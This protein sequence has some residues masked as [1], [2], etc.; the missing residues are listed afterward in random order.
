[1]SPD[2]MLSGGGPYLVACPDEPDRERGETHEPEQPSAPGGDGQA[3]RDEGVLRRPG[4]LRA[5]HR[6]GG[7]PELPVR[8]RLG[9][10]AVLHEPR[11]E[12]DRRAFSLRREGPH[13]LHPDTGR[14]REGGRDDVS[15]RRA[16][17]PARRPSLG[18][19][20]LHHARP[21][22]DRPGF[23]SRPRRQSRRG[24]EELTASFRSSNCCAAAG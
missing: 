6:D 16:R 15:R 13:H 1:M 18:L 9:P 2:T 4:R 17:E 7:L 14:R 10:G 11:S 3:G 8:Q 5:R 24:C 23:L 21:Q 20:Q 19:A 22:R 12:P